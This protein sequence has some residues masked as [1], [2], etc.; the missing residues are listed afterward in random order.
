MAESCRVWLV[1]AS[2]VVVLP[3]V[4]VRVQA[5]V[6]SAGLLL[7]TEQV[8]FVDPFTGSLVRVAM[9]LT[10]GGSMRKSVCTQNQ[11]RKGVC[12]SSYVAVH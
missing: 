3:L 1:S 8:R 2:S 10:S 6:K 9:T 4:S 12:E 11:E 7:R 5:T